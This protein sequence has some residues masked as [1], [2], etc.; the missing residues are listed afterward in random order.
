MATLRC[1]HCGFSKDLPAGKLPQVPTRVTC[2]K[3]REPFAFPP[4]PAVS[5]PPAATAPV[6]AET[7]TL[8]CPHCRHQREVP[9]DKVPAKT[10]R[11]TCPACQK[12]FPFDGRRSRPD[13]TKPVSMHPVLAPTPKP[14]APPRRRK[15]LAGIGELFRRAGQTFTRRILTLI[16]IGLLGL[17]LAGIAY[18]LLG[19]VL[20]KLQGLTGNSPLVAIPAIIVLT[21]FS[22]AAGSAIAGGMT[23]AIV[24]RDLGVRVALG[25]GIQRW[26]SFFWLFALLGFVLGGGYFLLFI[27]GVLLTVW[28]IFAQ[29]VL[30][31]E[32][33]GGMDALLLSRA[34]VRGHG[35]AV[36]GRVLLLAVVN[37]VLAIIPVVGILFALL[38]IPFTL[39]YTHEIYRDLHEIKAPVIYTNTRGEKSKYLL[40]GAAGFLLIA[41]AAFFLFKPMLTRYAAQVQI[42]MK[43]GEVVTLAPAKPAAR[44]YHQG[45]GSLQTTKQ[46]FAP[47][48]SIDVAFSAPEDLPDDAW[49]GVIPGEVPHGDADL[50][51]RN[52][53][54][55]QSLG[56]QHAGN[57]QFAAPGTPGKYSLRMYDTADDGIEIA[58]LSFQV[59][60]MENQPAPGPQQKPPIQPTMRAPAVSGPQL[61]PDRDRYLAGEAISLRFSGLLRPALTDRVAL[62]LVGS[63]NGSPVESKYLGQKSEGELQFTAPTLP[64]RYEFRLLPANSEAATATSPAISVAAP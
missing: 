35:W 50:A 52:R 21:L 58:T 26:R 59:V 17:A 56:G 45:S 15:Q 12:P 2:P 55:A 27:P 39:I 32:D 53:I 61:R 57:L 9:R 13:D 44:K 3:C 29:F 62:F 23:Y 54:S 43:P 30:A 64:G 28:F 40:T 37:L 60:V 16:G 38:L 19:G 46:Y 7:V 4:P 24:D 10:I 11:V 22:L 41:A 48:E 34:Y 1:P 49:I 25:Y 8:A 36:L 5:S 51:E 42:G 33:V 18:L 20:G 31:H 63:D 6:Q 47:G 14:A